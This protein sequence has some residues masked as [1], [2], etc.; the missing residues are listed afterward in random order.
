MP[1]NYLY[2]LISSSSSSLS[3][4]LC[5]HYIV[6]CAAVL[7]Y[8][9]YATLSSIIIIRVVY[10]PYIYYPLRSSIFFAP[11]DERFH[12]LYFSAFLFYFI[13]V[14][15][16]WR[17]SN[18]PNT[19][20]NMRCDGVW[21][22]MMIIIWTNGDGWYAVLLFL[23]TGWFYFTTASHTN[24]KRTILDSLLLQYSKWIGLA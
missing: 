9:G 16:L 18:E 13:C 10:T 12:G 22:K 17:R 15:L 19:N 1:I 3:E 20:T 8:L 2:V 11:F 23:L 14:A 7:V 21:N 24:S 6:E 4:P 5:L